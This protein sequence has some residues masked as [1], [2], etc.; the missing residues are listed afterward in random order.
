MGFKTAY[1]VVKLWRYNSDTKKYKGSG[2]MIGTLQQQLDYTSEEGKTFYIPKGF[3]TNFA[4]TPKFLWSLFP[5]IDK[6]T[7]ASIL[8]DW[9]Y[10]GNGVANRKEADKLFYEAGLS[11]GM[12]KFSM[13]IM[14]LFVRAFA[15][16]AY[17]SPEG[18]S[19]KIDTFG[20][21]TIVALVSFALGIAS[22]FIFL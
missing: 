22:L 19:G 14:W 15:W 7:N 11:C 17:T 4:S 18:K 6:Y 2:N 1:C 3:E 5:P 12:S 20:L 8:H 13:R 16:L 21:V 10:E 9:C